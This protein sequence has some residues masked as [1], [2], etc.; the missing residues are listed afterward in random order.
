MAKASDNVFPKLIYGTQT[1]N[2]A[3]P[4][5]GSWKTFSKVDGIYARSS[6]TVV[7]PF[8]TAGAGAAGGFIFLEAHTAST[9][10]TLDFTT[11]IS[12]T[13]DTYVIKLTSLVM[14]TNSVDLL[15]RMGTG[16]GP[17]YD[18]G[19]NY[20]GD[21]F[22]WRSGGSALEGGTGATSI[23]LTYGSHINNGTA[24]LAGVSGEFHLYDPQSTALYKA[25]S[26]RSVFYDASNFRVTTDVR[27]AYEST[28]A[29]TA[30][31]FFASSGNITSGTIR[32]Y[33][34]TK[35]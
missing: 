32:I 1:T 13:Y 30:V 5:D 11:F 29:V 20:S 4:T 14:A 35:S 34:L 27:G 3:A 8:G 31:R 9:S 6:N 26:G 16:G 17:T 28:T 2:P 10:A 7:G 25:V 12:S 22:V 23:Q 18:T 33:G 15:M 19:A 21:R 24:A